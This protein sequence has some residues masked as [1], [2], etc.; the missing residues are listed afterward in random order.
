MS[1]ALRRRRSQAPKEV[2]LSIPFLRQ[3]MSGGY[4]EGER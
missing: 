4:A 3:L 1:S 2:E